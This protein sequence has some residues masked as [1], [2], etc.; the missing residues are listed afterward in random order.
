MTTGCTDGFSCATNTKNKNTCVPKGQCGVVDTDTVTCTDVGTTCDSTK[1][2]G[3]TCTKDLTSCATAPA[4]KMNKCIPSTECNTTVAEVKTTCAGS[5]PNPKGK[6]C[7][8]NADDKGCG[9]GKN[10]ATAPPDLKDT[11]VASEACG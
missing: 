5:D 3:S 2:D 11:C 8:P 9:D 10:C 4:S 6:A 1:T 7:D